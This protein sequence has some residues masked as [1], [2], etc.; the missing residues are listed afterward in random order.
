MVPD[1]LAEAAN[2]ERGSGDGRPDAAGDRS[3]SLNSLGFLKKH[4]A[5]P[6][7]HHAIEVGT[8][9]PSA[10]VVRVL[11]RLVWLHGLD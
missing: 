5:R 6:S 3:R 7:G 4:P 1:G 10:R 8:S 11:D 2:A 9:L